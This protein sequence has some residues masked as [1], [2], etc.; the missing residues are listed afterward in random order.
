MNS[1][2]PSTPQKARILIADD[3]RD[4]RGI[5]SACLEEAGYE[6]E[7]ALDADEA[8]VKGLAHRPDL[9]LLD[10]LMPRKDGF[11]LCHEL[12]TNPVLK[13]TPIILISG[14]DSAGDRLKG[15]ES[16]CDEFLTKPV[17]RDE[18]LGRVQTLLRL[19]FYRSQL[20]ERK[21]FEAVLHLVSD[22]ILVLDPGGRIA[23]LNQAAAR[24]LNL[25]AETARGSNLFD[26]IYHMFQVS[27]PRQLLARPNEKTLRF[28]V[29]RPEQANT[30]SLSLSANLDI[31]P[32]P[33]GGIS[34]SVLTLRDVTGSKK[35]TKLHRTF[36]SLVS[37][38]L[39]TPIAAIAEH[40]SL[41]QD[42]LLGELNDEQRN[43]VDRVQDQTSRLKGLVEK[44]LSFIQTD[45][46]V[47]DHAADAFLMDE[48]IKK[49]VERVTARHPDK[50]TQIQY[51]L[52]E[53][54]YGLGISEQH[55]G[56]IIENLV[57][58]AIKFCEKPEVEVTIG[59]VKTSDGHHE[60]FV[61]DNG[62]G[63]PH[64][65][66]ERVFQEF[67]QIDLYFTGNVAGVGLGL[68]LTRRLIEK[69][70]GRIWITSELGRGAI[71]H[72]TLPVIGSAA[73]HDVGQPNA[74]NP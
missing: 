19:H 40:V 15:I 35:E 42:G 74:K 62:P 12:R 49:A 16:G 70:G 41:L 39:R 1:L 38:K 30:A 33:E 37:H 2:P 46:E 18:L 21:T 36:L 71:F 65:E 3:N 10:V 69:A 6:V 61:V 8:L 51:K 63:I 60:F 7:T 24:L 48:V 5:L 32:L 43:S 47:W 11:E 20:D 4:S 25:D 22:G 68:A 29:S 57:D 13:Q 23:S 26:W 54:L 56:I 67:Y 9:F 27:V 53:G 17:P 72:F 34:G 28:E 66:F 45:E 64:E 58:N 14:L 52:T 59:Y 55:F 44:M 31:I 50:K 73:P